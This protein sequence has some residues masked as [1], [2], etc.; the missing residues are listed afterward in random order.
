MERFSHFK[1]DFVLLLVTILAALGW[2]FSKEAL[3]EMPPLLF[4]G[5]RF[6]AA[7]LF[8][9]L[10]HRN[11]WKTL[12]QSPKCIRV[13]LTGLVMAAALLSWITG[14]ARTE[15][16]G[17]GAFIT[18]MGVLFV[19]MMAWVLFRS[20]INTSTWMALPVAAGGLALLSLGGRSLDG[21]FQADPG[22]VWF[23]SAS[24]LFALH[25]TLLSRLAGSVS[26]IPLTAA[27][28]VV[29]GVA[30]LIVSALTETWPDSV[31]TEIWWWVLASTLIGT[32]LRFSLQTYGQSLAPVSHA[33][34]IMILEPVWTATA[35][36]FWFG[37]TMDQQQ[38]IGCFL[39]FSALIIGRWRLLFRGS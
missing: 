21:G 19:P 37:E 25:F 9:F 16:I 15:N 2:I 13:W 32:S 23:M 28:L 1:A 38:V 12:R 3:A 6:L 17:V 26:A 18:I 7:G 39:I 24:F 30:G 35:A 20:A 31:S 27:Q 10:I 5:V 22:L 29:V 11:S 8:L 14:L 33:A 4:I 36:A 34:L